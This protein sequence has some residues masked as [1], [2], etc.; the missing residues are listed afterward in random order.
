MTIS[1]CG[2]DENNKYSG[3][4]AGDQTGTEWYLRSWWNYPWSCV[5]HH[6]DANVRSTIA[7]LAK[8]AAENNLIGYDQSERLTFW[9]HLR[10]SNYRPSQITIACEADCSSGVAAI[11]KATGYLLGNTALQNVSES[12][13]TGNLE[14]ALKSAGFEARRDSKYLNSENYNSAGDIWLNTQNHTCIQVTEGANAG[15]GST[16]TT[17]S[18][19]NTSSSNGKLDVDGEWGQATTRALQTYLGTGVDGIVSNQLAAYKAQ[20]PGLLSSSWE[21]QST[22]RGGSDMVRAMQSRLGV[23]A[24]GYIGPNTIKALQTRM[25][26]YVDGVISNPSDCVK[27]LQSRLNNNSF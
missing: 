5:L 26:T 8:E 3:G 23:T 17:T 21:W 4:T 22:K 24:D 1:N 10:A 18:S 7:Q 6:P 2:H 16:T 19:A 14:A 27:A 11:V 20:N 9:Q 13:W 12:C 25:G 15:S